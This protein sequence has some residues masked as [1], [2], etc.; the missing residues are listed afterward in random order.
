M[1]LLL[2]LLTAIGLSPSGSSPTLVQRNKNN[3][4][5]KK[6]QSNKNKYTREAQKI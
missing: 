3:T 6:L 5:N 1:L 4:R 2:L